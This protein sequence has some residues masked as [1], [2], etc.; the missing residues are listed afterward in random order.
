M[1]DKRLN[2]VKTII[3]E[4]EQNGEN[5]VLLSR[6]NAADL[7]AAQER[8]RLAEERAEREKFWSHHWQHEHN[9]LERKVEWLEQNCRRLTDLPQTYAGAAYAVEIT[10]QT[11]K[12]LAELDA[13]F[14]AQGQERQAE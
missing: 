1:D 13:E 9:H 12:K 3:A 11:L 14:E 7:V 4:A 10:T 5:F 8:A 2:D 6:E